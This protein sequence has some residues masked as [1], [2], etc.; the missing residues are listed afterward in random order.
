L[1]IPASRVAP[2][3]V[4]ARG[5]GSF[6]GVRTC[7][8]RSRVSHDWP[9]HYGATGGRC[10]CEQITVCLF[11]AGRRSRAADHG[12]DDREGPPPLARGRGSDPGPPPGR[13]VGPVPTGTNRA[14]GWGAKPCGVGRVKSRTD[15]HQ[16]PPCPPFS[17]GTADRPGIP[18]G[19]ARPGLRSAV[20]YG[21]I[22][23]VAVPATL[24][25][26]GGSAGALI[27]Q[28]PTAGRD[29]SYSFGRM[30]AAYLAS[31]GFALAY[32]YYAAAHRPAERVMIP[33]L[34]ILQSVPI[35]GFFPVAIL[36]FV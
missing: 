7:V 8:A 24:I 36:F 14:A 4:S 32:G 35:L 30:L 1:V 20:L 3:G 29:L 18:T 6:H 2:A 15:R 23:A 11:D 26:W 31:L 16:Q 10:R 28:L 13:A 9:L 22:L 17:P 34:D 19:W 12:V 27:D 5:V 25:N 21:A 33:V